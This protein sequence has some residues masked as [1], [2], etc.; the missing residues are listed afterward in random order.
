MY[1]CSTGGLY[2]LEENNGNATDEQRTSDEIKAVIK[3]HHISFP[4]NGVADRG[5]RLILSR[6]QVR[7]SA[8][9]KLR[10]AINRFLS[11]RIVER[12]RFAQ[13]IRMKLL[14]RR[15]QCGDY[16]DAKRAA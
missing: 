4:M 6:C 16:R 2:F 5:D 10:V 12:N 15:E 7:S 8:D 1:G 11:R 14:S 3:C 9:K 13:P